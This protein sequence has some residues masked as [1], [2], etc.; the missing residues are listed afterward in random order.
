[1]NKRIFDLPDAPLPLDPDSYYEVLVPDV[2]SKSGYTSCKIKPNN[3]NGV[4]V[5]RAIISKG[6]GAVAPTSVILENTLGFVPAFAYDSVGYYTLSHTNGFDVTK[7]FINY[8]YDKAIPGGETLFQ[9][10]AYKYL[11]D[12]S[13]IW[14]ET[15]KCVV[16]GSD[17][18]PTYDDSLLLFRPLMIEIL[19]YP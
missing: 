18:T 7:T 8:S 10:Y 5:Y 1:M 15:Y 3:L 9:M 4:K 17:V 16:V 12:N 14:V 6:A 13:T 2:T 19:V 11:G